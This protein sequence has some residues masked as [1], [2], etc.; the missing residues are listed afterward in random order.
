MSNAE[1]LIPNSARTPEE[2]K[3]L[4]RKMG[5]ASGV[6]RRR[7]KSLREAADL[8]MS[9]PVS[10]K[11]LRAKLKAMG[12]TDDEIDNQMA[13]IV[14][15]FGRAAKGDPKASALLFELLEDDKTGTTEQASAHNS[16]VDAIRERN[17]EN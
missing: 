5:I 17:H 8:L 7:K 9:M 11:K 12:L 4:A 10:D 2:R 16:L 1:N 6:S 13:V 3:E 15:L 14:G